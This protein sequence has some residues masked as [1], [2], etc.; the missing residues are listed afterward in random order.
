MHVMV[1]SLLIENSISKYCYNTTTSWY[2]EL[3]VSSFLV[4]IES[5]VKTR[6]LYDCWSPTLNYPTQALNSCTALLSSTKDYRVTSWAQYSAT[7]APPQRNFTY[8]RI[9]I[10]HETAEIRHAS[11]ALLYGTS[12][13]T[14]QRSPNNVGKTGCTLDIGF[15]TD[16]QATFISAIRFSYKLVSVCNVFV[17]L[18]AT[19]MRSSAV[20]NSLWGDVGCNF[21]TPS[22]FAWVQVPIT[23]TFTSTSN[24]GNGGL[25][26][27][28]WTFKHFRSTL[29]WA[30]PHQKLS[31]H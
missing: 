8:S 27:K 2:V 31:L 28:N 17:S 9:R 29:H 15:S 10:S 13:T 25:S 6:P 22:A 11:A 5:A 30:R 20:R 7:A 24:P 21:S 14:Q 19:S 23:I 3:N 1:K 4:N 16:I 18:L 26:I 12:E